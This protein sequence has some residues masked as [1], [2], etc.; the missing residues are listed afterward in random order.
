LSRVATSAALLIALAAAA[1]AAAAELRGTVS[2]V[3]DKGR[4]VRGAAGEAVVWFVP[5]RAVR[6][7]PP[8]ERE[9]VTRRKQFEPRVLVVP[10]GSTVRFP[11]RDPILH[12]VFSVSGGNRFDLGLVPEGEGGSHRFADAGVVRV[13][14]NV[15]HSMV[16]YVVVL[17]SPFHSVPAAGGSFRLVGLPAGPGTLHAW[18]ERGEVA[19]VRADPAAAAAAAVRVVAT[20]PLVPPHLNKLGRPYARTRRDRY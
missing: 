5:D 16:G 10:A 9:M 7:A 19:S 14:C 6:P 2:V 13:F 18:H 12:N 4:P 17:D 1:P 15:H 11:N 3:D 20:K 8:V